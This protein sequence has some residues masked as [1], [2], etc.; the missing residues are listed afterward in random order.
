MFENIICNIMD[1]LKRFQD[2]MEL[3]GR[4]CAF[5]MIRSQLVN[6]RFNLKSL[7]RSRSFSSWDTCLGPATEPSDVRCEVVK[8]E[9][10]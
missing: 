10:L 7:K 6:V 9:E 5:F 2:K 8:Q 3:I 4:L 1:C